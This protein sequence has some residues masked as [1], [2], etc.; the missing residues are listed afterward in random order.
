[1]R[2][3]AAEAY[4]EGVFAL[5]DAVRELLDDRLAEDAEELVLARRVSA[6]GRTRAYV[7]GRSATAA[8]LRDA[9]AALLSF[10]GQHEHRKLML[11]SAQLEILDGFAGPE[12]AQRRDAYREL[13]VQERALHT[14][15]AELRERAGARDRELDLLVWELEEIDRA[16]PSE[17]EETALE[18]E[19]SRLRHVEALRSAAAAGVGALAGDA[20]DGGGA[21]LALAS[22]AAALESTLGVDAELDVLAARVRAL[23]LE[24]EDLVHELHRYAEGVEAAPGRLDEVEE[25][26]TL[27]DRL[28]RK[29]GG[30]IAAVLEHAAA[31]RARHAELAGVEEAIEE[32]EHELEALRARLEKA[33][34][35]LG[36][37]RVRGRGV[38]GRHRP[39]TPGGAGHGRRGV[40]RRALPA[41]RRLRADRRRRGR[42]PDR[43][44]P[45]CAGGPAA[46]D[47]VPAASSRG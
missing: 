44:Q 27:L 34:A 29:H 40:H 31:C 15:L 5:P 19:R 32:T 36:T 3:G 14:R 23:S 25:R 9:G 39:G 24:A 38:A 20:E 35:A 2:P 22:A 43:A 37:A 30:T 4:V 42:V 47:G 45:G 26:L 12:Q 13:Y 18:S 28:K 8:D 33:A 7:G 16:E 17:E 6:E 1:M 11:A 46:R 41:R 10:Y 21:S